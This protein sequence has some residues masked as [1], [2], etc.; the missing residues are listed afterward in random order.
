M[1][2]FV[3]LQPAATGISTLQYLIVLVLLGALLV[4]SLASLLQCEH[5]WVLRWPA[6]GHVSNLLLSS[7]ATQRTYILRH[8][9]GLAN[10]LAGLAALN[11]GVSRGVV[12]AEQCRWL[13]ATAL[14]VMA[15]FYAL[16]RSGVNRH[17]ADP[18]MVSSQIMCANIFLA[19]GYYLG[20]PCR[21]IA[22]MLLSVIQMFCIFTS[23]PRV[24][25][26][27]GIVAALAFGVAMS[28]IAV[29]E[30]HVIN[31]PEIQMVYFGVLV[32]TLIS[33]Y[34]LVQ[35][36]T[37]MR[38]TSAQRKLELSEALSR[39]QVLATRDDLTGLYNRRHM[40]EQ[41]N[42]ERHRSNR[43]GRPFCIA[44]I[45]IDHFKVVNDT[46]GHGVGD[47]VL[48]HV[49]SAISVGLRETDVVARWGGEEFLVMFTDTDCE[50]AEMVLGRILR[51]LSCSVVSGAQP[52]LRVTF[53]AGVTAFES[54]ELLTRTVD[55]A[56]RALYRAKAAGR[57]RVMRAEP[58]APMGLL[59]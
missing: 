16:I 20:G 9:V 12:D 47:E 39:I 55:R 46:Y 34:L 26:K 32:I 43:T 2:T 25:I 45:D 44:L 58:Q 41:L 56:D 49:A 53:S 57:N 30:K 3:A 8:L 37:R 7:D 51:A 40:L 1:S 18:S 38:N 15:I 5:K 6:L 33:T 50:T 23:S 54:D 10:C 28:R 52:D 13:T 4:A 14:G 11:Y 35:Q 21:P 27:S 29:N 22:L 24:L 19:W 48:G 59:A 36:L 17:F 42:I 31:G